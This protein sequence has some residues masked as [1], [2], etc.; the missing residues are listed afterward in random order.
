MPITDADI[1]FQPPNM[2]SRDPTRKQGVKDKV[3]NA[4]PSHAVK[5]IIV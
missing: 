4:A 5:A 3:R 1:S 2:L